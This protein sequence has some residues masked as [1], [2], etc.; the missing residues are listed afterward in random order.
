M[1]SPLCSFQ[2]RGDE[3]VQGMPDTEESFFSIEIEFFHF[4]LNMHTYGM[5]Y[6]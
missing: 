6:T 5:E 1:T 4:T 2:T 3:R